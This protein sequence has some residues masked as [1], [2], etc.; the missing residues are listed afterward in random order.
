MKSRHVD[1]R[2][3]NQRSQSG[4]VFDAICAEEGLEP[5]EFLNQ[6]KAPLRKISARKLYDTGDRVTYPDPNAHIVERHHG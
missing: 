2:A 6:I 5:L 1:S 3:R 4:Q